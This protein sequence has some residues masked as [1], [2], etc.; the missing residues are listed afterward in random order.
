MNKEWLSLAQEKKK[1]QPLDRTPVSPLAGPHA[2]GSKSATDKVPLGSLLIS[3]K[4]KA[5][6]PAKVDDTLSGLTTVPQ[7]LPGSWEQTP[8][9]R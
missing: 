2:W 8:D 6:S 7:T 4:N 9:H 1:A 3:H 5:P